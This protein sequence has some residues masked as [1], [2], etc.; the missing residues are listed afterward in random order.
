MCGIA[1]FISSEFVGA[2]RRMSEILVSMTGRLTHRGP[3]GKGVW[4][5]EEHG[6]GLGH[7]R[8]SI[9]GFERGWEQPMLSSCGRM[10]ITFNGE[11]YNADKIR[12]ELQ[13]AGRCFRGSSDTEVLVEACAEFGVTKAVQ[14]CIGMFAFVLWDKQQKGLFLVRDRLGK[15]PLYFSHSEGELVFAS[16]LSAF[17]PFKPWERKIDRQSLA[18]FLV[19]GYV[20]DPRSIYEGISKLEPGHIATFNLSG[21]LTIEPY[22]SLDDVV[23]CANDPLRGR[24]LD[25]AAAIATARNLLTDSVESRLKA[26]VPVGIFL[27]GGF[28]S[29]IVAAVAA[30]AL[31]GQRTHTFFYRF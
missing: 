17:H 25:D 13:K 5:D 6:V 18:S 8:L 4:S 12:S 19:L 7:T 11:I 15:K 9:F 1:G 27:S 23:F 14:K 10:V 28:D 21:D 31:G 22:W 2:S 16:E 20:P 26:D 29:T 24:H 30:N 3:D